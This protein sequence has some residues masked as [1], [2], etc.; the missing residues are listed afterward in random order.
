M[1]KMNNDRKNLQ[2]FKFWLSLTSHDQVKKVLHGVFLENLNS[3]GFASPCS[4]KHNL[5]ICLFCL[6]YTHLN[7]D[8]YIHLGTIHKRRLLK[9]VD[10]WGPGPP[11][12]D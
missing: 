7:L 12:G 4:T 2:K 5:K 8:M 1:I 6:Q 3:V 9:G 10:S 11:K